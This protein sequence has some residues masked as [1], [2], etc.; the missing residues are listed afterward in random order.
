VRHATISHDLDRTGGATYNNPMTNTDTAELNTYMWKSRTRSAI[1]VWIV[2]FTYWLAFFLVL[3]PGNVFGAMGG[4]VAS[5]EMLRIFA[6]ALLGSSITPLVLVSVRRFPVEG[7]SA[8][9]NAAIQ[10][11]GSLAVSA[12]LM[13]VSCILAELLFPAG[14]RP[15]VSALRREFEFNWL[16][17]AFCTVTFVWFS[18]TRFAEYLFGIEQQ[19]GSKAPASAMRYFSS[20]PVKVRGELV[21]VQ[22][23]NVDWI[24]AQGNY[25][26]L[27]EGS[28][29]Y[30]I[31]D[32]IGKIEANLD[33]GEFVRV[34]RGA[35]VS[36]NRVEGMSPLGSG[37][38]SLR[39]K[40]GAELRLSRKYRA[41]FVNAWR[42]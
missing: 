24:E 36:V 7:T 6:A 30:L 28:E 19:R 16:L 9:R 40:G 31:R 12:G 38:A 33:P 11:G 29:T 13:V 37:D 26:A 18:H 27:H 8:W 41:A 3:E 32:S 21:H 14:H 34:H 2:G 42:N 1:R 23:S 4:L 25:L 22:L 39:L 35:I 15:F 20:I 17:V 10:L 5:H